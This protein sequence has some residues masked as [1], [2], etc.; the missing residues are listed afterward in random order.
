MVGEVAGAFG[1]R[2]GGFSKGEGGGCFAWPLDLGCGAAPY[3]QTRPSYPG[4]LYLEPAPDSGVRPFFE[5]LVGPLSVGPELA[6]KL[7]P[8]L[9][10]EPPALPPAFL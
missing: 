1:G 10:P 7:P 3:P 4:P 6:S 2:C 9:G 5:W 8:V